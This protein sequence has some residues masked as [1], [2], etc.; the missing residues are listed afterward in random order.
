MSLPYIVTTGPS[1]SYKSLPEEPLYQNNADIKKFAVFLV[2]F[3]T[4]NL[5]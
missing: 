3:F 5:L 4:E 1:G 2:I